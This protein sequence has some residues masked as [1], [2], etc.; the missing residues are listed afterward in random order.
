MSH[1]D[2]N[3][4]L[5]HCGRADSPEEVVQVLIDQGIISTTALRDLRVV[6]QYTKRCKQ[7]RPEAAVYDIAETE[8]IS[9]RTVYRA[10]KKYSR[11]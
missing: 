1:E 8:G 2:V 6:Y 5:T 11:E 3:I 4:I 10:R 7:T 9:P